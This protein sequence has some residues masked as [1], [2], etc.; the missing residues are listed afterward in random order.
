MGTDKALL[1]W[2]PGETRQTFLS[3]AIRL[4]NAFNDMVIVVVGNNEASLAPAVYAT[5]ALLVRN[6]APERGQLSSLQVG[7]EE[8]LNQGRD[9]AMITL[10]DR[11]PVAAATLKLLSDAFE[12]ALKQGKW[13]VVPEHQGKHGHPI[14]AGRE[15][16]EAFLRAPAS[17]TAREIEH[18]NEAHIQYVPV[19][20]PYVT[21]NVNT[22]EE[23]AGLAVPP[24]A[25]AK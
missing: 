12:M 23:Y 18:L 4:L 22:P 25:R 6:P 2:P 3:A 9:A 21:A 19:D 15:M 17:S 5:S 7:L 10:V 1:P 24:A 13:A 8:V 16:I 11:P 14:L 20:D